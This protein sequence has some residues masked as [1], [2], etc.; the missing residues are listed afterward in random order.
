MSS[1][2]I[3]GYQLQQPAMPRFIKVFPALSVNIQKWL[4]NYLAFEKILS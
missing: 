2:K 3:I 4:N 1:N